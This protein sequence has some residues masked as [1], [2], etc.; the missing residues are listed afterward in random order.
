MLVFSILSD[1][2]LATGWLSKKNT[3]RLFIG[4]GTILPA[5]LIFGLSFASCQHVVL[6]V[7]LLSLVVA[8]E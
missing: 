7:A 3:R 8:F 1:K 5:I 4:I 2:L 6:A